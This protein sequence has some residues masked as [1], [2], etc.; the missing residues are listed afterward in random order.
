MH[1]RRNAESFHDTDRVKANRAPHLFGPC[2][3]ETRLP[4]SRWCAGVSPSSSLVLRKCIADGTLSRSRHPDQPLQISQTNLLPARYPSLQGSNRP[5]A[6]I[7]QRFSPVLFDAL[8]RASFANPFHGD[9][10]CRR[11]QTKREFL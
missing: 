5:V 8:Q 11:R 3:I 2:T 4:R 7:S 6:R 1:D 9:Q 10:E